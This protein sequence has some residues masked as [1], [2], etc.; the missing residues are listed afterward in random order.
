MI[1]EKTEFLLADDG[2]NIDQEDRL[3]AIKELRGLEMVQD[4]RGKDENV[5]GL[6]PFTG[7]EDGLVKLQTEINRL[8]EENERL[9]GLVGDRLTAPHEPK[10]EDS[11]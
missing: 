5:D 10:S 4:D 6:G 1:E 9:R 8:R 11:A 3:R 2:N 7:I